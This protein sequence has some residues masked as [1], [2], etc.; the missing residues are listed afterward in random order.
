MAK[1]LILSR[2]YFPNWMTIVSS[3]SRLVLCLSFLDTNTPFSLW[4]YH[5]IFC[6]AQRGNPEGSF[7]TSSCNT[8][9]GWFKHLLFPTGSKHTCG[10]WPVAFCWSLFHRHCTWTV[11]PRCGWSCARS[12]ERSVWSSSYRQ[13]SWMVFH[14]CGSSCGFSG[15]PS[16]WTSSC[17]QCS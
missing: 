9:H 16:G 6:V 12:D 8:D 11:S 3:S 7:I 4:S 10:S 15:C 17:T 2:S 5:H 14:L 13:S 1:F